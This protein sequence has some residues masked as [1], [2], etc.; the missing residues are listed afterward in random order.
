M[1]GEGEDGHRFQMMGLDVGTQ[2][3]CWVGA[4]PVRKGLSPVSH[5]CCRDQ[6]HWGG[7]DGEKL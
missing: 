4:P 2:R 6:E 7:G 3:C 5:R 1:Q